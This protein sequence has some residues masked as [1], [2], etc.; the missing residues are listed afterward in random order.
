MDT[1]RKLEILA[2]D[3]RYDLSCACGSTD[4]DRRKRNAKGAWVYPASLPRGGKGI[5]LK[6]LL[7]NR[8]KNDC[9]YCPLRNNRDYRRVSMPPEELA[10]AY[11][12]IRR[13]L[14]HVHG[15]FLTSGVEYSPDE[16]MARMTAVGELLRK[17][18]GY[19]GF[20]HLKILPGASEAA[21]EEALSLADAVSVNVEA[22]TQGSF[23][24][25]SNTKNFHRDIVRPIRHISRLTQRG[26]RFAR[27]K[28]TTQ[29]I[30]G[31]ATENDH[32]I[33]AA[34][35]GLYRRL[36]LNRVYYSAYQRGLGETSL[37][38]ENATTASHDLL[39]REHRLYQAD[40]LLRKYGW[41]MQD[42][43]FEAGG[44]FSLTTDPKQQ[45]AD[46]HPEQ[47]PL[48]LK[49]ASRE[50]L[51]R[52][53]GLGPITVGRILKTRRKGILRGLRDVG[54]KGKRLALASRYVVH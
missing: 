37:P 50:E 6:T 43:V 29:F 25:L 39:T 15:L 21:I 41:D 31:A 17:R 44:N 54:V 42:F 38:G 26:E 35:F 3:A 9:R 33:V 18:H 46:R 49:S 45:W 11:M 23:S 22:P 10:T 16:S 32:D 5:I 27:V 14:D 48:S 8:C 36:G 28:Q 30:V 4:Q 24:A 52:V 19:R 20:L 2:E 34:T 47:F 40:F 7:S 1:D 53:P 13:R 12:D 51:L